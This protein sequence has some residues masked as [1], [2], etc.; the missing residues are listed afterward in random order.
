VR[1]LGTNLSLTL[2]AWRLRCV[3]ALED[4]VDGPDG[5]EGPHVERQAYERMPHH[6]VRIDPPAASQ[7][8]N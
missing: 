8:R 7:R 1:Y 2:G 5:D 6:V 3:L 4:A